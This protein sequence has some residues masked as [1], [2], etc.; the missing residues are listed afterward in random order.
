VTQRWV[1]KEALSK[2]LGTGLRLRFERVTVHVGGV[3][4][5]TPMIRFETPL[6][7]EPPIAGPIRARLTRVGAMCVALVMIRPPQASP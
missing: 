4:G 3:P 2:A 7:R 5:G 6:V 1:L